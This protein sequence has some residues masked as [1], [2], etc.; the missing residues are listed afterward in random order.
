MIPRTNFGTK[1]PLTTSASKISPFLCQMEMMENK[2][3]PIWHIYI[4]DQIY[5]NG[6][7][8]HM[9][10]A[11]I[12]IY[13]YYVT[14]D[15]YIYYVIYDIFWYKWCIYVPLDGMGYPTFRPKKVH[16]GDTQMIPGLLS[17]V[18]CCIHHTA[19]WSSWWLAWGP[20]PPP[21]KKHGF[22][23]SVGISGF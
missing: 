1:K 16:H 9:F 3:I 15:I 4:Y 8:E 6:I 20:K 18:R 21:K 11:Y 23:V 7:C 17:G 5:Q 22:L 13:I 19:T 2:M 12:Y 10:G 14:C